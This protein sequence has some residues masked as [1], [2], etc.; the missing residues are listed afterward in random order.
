MGEDISQRI[1]LKQKGGGYVG[2][3]EICPWN[4]EDSSFDELIRGRNYDLFSLFGSSRGNYRE[5]GYGHYGMPEFAKGTLLEKFC[6]E[7][8]RYGFVWYRLP[9]LR[10]A[11]S[12]RLGEI[13]RPWDYLDEDS[14]DRT[15]WEELLSGAGTREGAVK[16]AEKYRGWLDEHRNVISALEDM[17]DT[18]GRFSS[19]ADHKWLANLIDV[20]ESVFLFFFDN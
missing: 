3:H 10:K 1:Y 8:C 9:D 13:G 20:E 2:A 19:L 14:E 12:E 15:D 18:L 11:V 16:F 17:K 4:P 5:L 7:T 6:M